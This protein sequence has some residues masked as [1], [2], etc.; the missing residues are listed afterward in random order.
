MDAIKLSSACRCKER[1]HHRWYTCHSLGTVDIQKFSKLESVAVLT[2][3]VL[4]EVPQ[5][6]IFSATQ[7]IDISTKA[8]AGVLVAVTRGP[9]ALREL[10]PQARITLTHSWNPSISP[11]HFLKEARR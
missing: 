3:T 11:D 8:A 10:P 9:A 2:H 7:D 4:P 1:V 5:T 6:A